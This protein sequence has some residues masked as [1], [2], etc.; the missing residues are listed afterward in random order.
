MHILK[1]FLFPGHLDR[2]VHGVT[3][4]DILHACD[5]KQIV[6]TD[7]TNPHISLAQALKRRNLATF[8][9]MAQQKIQQVQDAQH[10][11]DHGHPHMHLLHRPDAYPMLIQGLRANTKDADAHVVFFDI[12]SLIS[13]SRQKESVQIFTLWATIPYHL[14][15]IESNQQITRSYIFP[16]DGI[17][18]DF[19]PFSYSSVVGRGICANVTRHFGGSRTFFQQGYF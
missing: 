13:K 17:A 2:V 3:A 15:K 16:F 11:H 19:E 4:E 8:R 7:V 10:K 12:E 18:E 5:Q 6:T 1:I 9:N 14:F